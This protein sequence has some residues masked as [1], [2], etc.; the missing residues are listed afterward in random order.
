VY[1]FGTDGRCWI[2]NPTSCSGSQTA[3]SVARGGRQSFCKVE[4]ET[5]SSAQAF[6]TES[7][8][9]SFITVVNVFAA[10]GLS[11]LVYGAFRHYIK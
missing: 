9:T 6:H 2:G 10:I 1:Q 7:A 5:M 3:I 11:A 4:A 8:A